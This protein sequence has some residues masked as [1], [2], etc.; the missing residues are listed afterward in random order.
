MSDFLPLPALIQPQQSLIARVYPYDPN[1]IA[2][3]TNEGTRIGP[4]LNQILICI[5]EQ[6]M[7]TLAASPERGRAGGRAGG[8]RGREAEIN[9]LKD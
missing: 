9:D 5:D 8:W 1:S 3:I 7:T 4:I 6:S 2:A